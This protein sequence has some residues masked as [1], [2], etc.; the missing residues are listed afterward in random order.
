MPYIGATKK[1]LTSRDGL[2]LLVAVAFHAAFLL[3]PV[4]QDKPMVSTNDSLIIELQNFDLVDQPFV[5]EVAPLPEPQTPEP[6]QPIEPVP[7]E[8]IPPTFEEPIREV[9]MEEE[10]LPDPDDPEPVDQ[11]VSTAVLLQSAFDRQWSLMEKESDRE[12]GVFVP[13]GIPDNWR[14]GITLEDNLFDGMTVPRKVEVVD[15]WI[16]A[17]GSQNMVINTPNGETLCG[18]GL[19]WDPMQPLVENVMQFRLCGGGGKRTFEMPDRYHKNRDPSG[20]A[21]STTN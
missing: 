5:Q 1:G 9:V 12:L 4:M 21:N 16:S 18:R 17:D 10:T 8:P 14:P 13:P 19:A 7:P 11:D 2:W 20:I 15:R 3:V 6:P